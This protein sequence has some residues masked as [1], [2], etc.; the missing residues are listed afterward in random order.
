[1]LK[2]T[3][4][5]IKDHNTRLV[6][7][8]IY[9]NNAVSRA[10]VARLTGLT[11]P[12][13]STI[14]G[15]L[16]DDGFVAEAGTGPS[17]GGKPPIWLQVAADDHLLLCLDVSRNTFRG[18]LINLRG[19]IVV[20]QEAAAPGLQGEAALQKAT[21]LIDGL[22][23]AA[24]QP[25]LGLSIGTPGLVNPDTGVVHQAVN[26]GWHDLPLA[27]QLETRYDKPVYVANDSYAAALAEYTFGEPRDSQNLILVKMGPGVGAGIILNGAI[28]PGDGLGAGEIGHVVV[29][30]DGELCSCGNHGCLETIASTRALIRQ[31]QVLNPAVL[32][33]A[34]VVAAFQS[35]DAAAHTVLNRAAA[36]LGIALANLIGILNIRHIRL[37]GD[38][39]ALGEPFVQLAT[40][41]IAHRVLPDMAAQTTITLATLGIESVMLGCA[42]LILKNELGII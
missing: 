32:D 37:G 40:Q 20:R 16:I 24:L 8:T 26:L 9:D 22:L 30:P 42:A 29:Q 4:Q 35:G 27:E 23:A 13:V 1:M 12:T 33:W 36:Y 11:R 41:N 39:L 28:Y 38:A 17:V 3:R 18:A 31:V 10:D 6:L 19:Q 25:I 5:H 7:K 15:A 2:A 21:E 14:V 34:G